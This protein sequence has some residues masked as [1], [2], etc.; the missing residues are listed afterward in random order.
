VSVRELLEFNWREKFPGRGAE[1]LIATALVLLPGGLLVMF[2]LWLFRRADRAAGK[3]MPLKAD[4][5]PQP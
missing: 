3:P 4:I 5:A 2:A 1:F